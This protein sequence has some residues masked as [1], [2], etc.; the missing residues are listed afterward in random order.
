[1]QVLGR[2]TLWTYISDSLKQVDSLTQSDTKYQM[3]SSALSLCSMKSMLSWPIHLTT[4]LI[5]LWVLLQ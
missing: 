4:V 3:R 5:R 1:M 2:Q